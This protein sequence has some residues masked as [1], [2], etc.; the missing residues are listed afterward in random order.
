MYFLV[1]SSERGYL[2]NVSISECGGGLLCVRGRHSSVL[3]ATV[4]CQLISV[5]CPVEVC[6]LSL[7]R[8]VI[9]SLSSLGV[10]TVAEGC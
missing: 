6:R 5:D 1:V 8:E 3:L 7:H 4:T 10:S 2:F 9:R